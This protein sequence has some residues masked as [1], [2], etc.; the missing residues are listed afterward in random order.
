MN[1]VSKS[2]GISISVPEVTPGPS[3]SAL[4]SSKAEESNATPASSITS[5][6]SSGALTSSL[7]SEITPSL[8][9]LLASE[10]TASTFVSGPLPQGIPT[11]FI[12][13]SIE[14]EITPLSEPNSQAVSIG[15]LT[16]SVEPEI[17]PSPSD[18]QDSETTPSAP[19]ETSDPSETT[20]PSERTE[21]PEISPP[22]KTESRQTDTALASPTST[23]P[24]TSST[25]STICS[26]STEGNCSTC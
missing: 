26:A 18:L 6:I 23:L 4:R 15:S 22:D 9:G 7:Q 20:D 1:T 5:M 16:H 19:A 14:P 10:T 25:S 8:L 2:S 3:N 17:T 11:K 24:A 13:S 21:T 12:I